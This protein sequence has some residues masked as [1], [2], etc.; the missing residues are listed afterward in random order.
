MIYLTLFA[1][2]GAYKSINTSVTDYFSFC[3]TQM[4]FFFCDVCHS[5]GRSNP[6]I[7]VSRGS[8][9]RAGRRRHSVKEVVLGKIA[10][11]EVYSLVK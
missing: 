1:N 9:S 5:G 3:L 2:F 4:V 7:D 6:P 11:L 10:S 8:I